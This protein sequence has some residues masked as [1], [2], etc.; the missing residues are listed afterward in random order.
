MITPINPIKPNQPTFG[1]YIKTKK[2]FYGHCDIGKFK[3]KNIE[4]Y[5]DYKDRTK[6]YYVSDDVRNWLKSKLIYFER[7]IKRIVRSES[8]KC[9]KTF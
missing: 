1:I 9:G 6:L 5:Y 7:G 4:I 3:N 2:T 8:S